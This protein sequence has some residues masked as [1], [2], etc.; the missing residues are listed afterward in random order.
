MSSRLGF[1]FTRD[2][3]VSALVQDFI[4]AQPEVYWCKGLPRLILLQC[5]PFCSFLAQKELPGGHIVLVPYVK[6][7]QWNCQCICLAQM[8]PLIAQSVSFALGPKHGPISSGEY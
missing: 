6:A 7:K 8:E 4:K 3:D 1:I 5:I 2:T